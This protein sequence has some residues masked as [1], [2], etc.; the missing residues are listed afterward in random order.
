M[1]AFYERPLD[2]NYY[3]EDFRCQ[4][5][6]TDD[7]NCSTLTAS[8]N[9]KCGGVTLGVDDKITLPSSYTTQ[10]SLSSGELGGI[11]RIVNSASYTVSTKTTWLEIPMITS[12][13]SM[14]Y[15][16]LSPGSYILTG[17]IGFGS[18]MTGL[19]M[20]GV[21][22]ATTSTLLQH[23]SNPD[24]DG[25]LLTQANTS[26]YQQWAVTRIVSV[27][28]D[29]NYYLYVFTDGGTPSIPAGCAVLKAIKIA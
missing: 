29:S 27:S 9:I 20:V 18:N 25:V 8:G 13:T 1:Q 16:K 23:I 21:A 19:N 6:N 17:S 12:P 26:L 24:P 10:P 11:K 22:V 4:D 28:E 2:D 3:M 5:L 14:N 15:I 7:I